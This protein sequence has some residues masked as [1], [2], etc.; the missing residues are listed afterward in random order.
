M[1]D[2]KRYL[3]RLNAQ[4]A[5]IER[6]TASPTS[7]AAAVREELASLQARLCALEAEIKTWECE[8]QIKVQNEPVIFTEAASEPE[9]VPPPAFVPVHSAPLLYE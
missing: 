8:Q 1:E 3:N 9:Q 4:F 5:D 2:D 7:E 6:L